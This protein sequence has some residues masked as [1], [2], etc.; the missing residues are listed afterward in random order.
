[1][2][3]NFYSRFLITALFFVMVSGSFAYAIRITT[4]PS[5]IAECS[6]F[7]GIRS[8]TV[9]A[10]GL[11]LTYQWQYRDGIKWT[12]IPHATGSTYSF[13]WERN[14]PLTTSTNGMAIRCRITETGSYHYTRIAYIWVNNNISTHPA[15]QAKVVGQSVTFTVAATG[16]GKLTY[17]W[18]KGTKNISGA[19]SSS[20]TI[21]SVKTGD[22]GSYNC[23]VTG[24]CNT[25]T[26]SSATLTVYEQVV[27]TKQPKPVTECEGVTNTSIQVTATGP[28]T[29]YQWQV[30]PYKQITWQ[31]ITGATSNPLVNPNPLS[32]VNNG[33]Q[34]RCIVYG[35]GGQSVTSNAA[36]LTV[37]QKAGI[38]GHPAS[39]TRNTGESVTF[40][41]SSTGYSRSW[42]WEVNKGSGWS[43]VAGATSSSLTLS[44]LTLSDAGSYRC[45]VYNICNTVHTNA[46]V[47]TIN[48]PPYPD[49]W[50][51]QNSGS[52]LNILAIH[53]LS[54]TKAW[55]VTQDQNKLLKTINGGETWLDVAASGNNYWRTVFFTSENIGFIGGYNGIART[56]DGGVNW[57]YTDL[58][59]QES[60]GA[61]EYFYI[62]SI[63][64]VNA[65]TGW[66]VG[67]GGI[68]YKTTNGGA[69][70]GKI[71]W[72][73]DNPKVTDINLYSVYFIN[74]NT[75]FVAGQNGAMY[76]T[77]EGGDTPA[78]WV[79]VTTGV[80]GSNTI[81]D[82]NF[83]NTEKGFFISTENKGLYSTINGGL[84]WTKIASSGLLPDVYSIYLRSL[85]FVDA[86]N[87]YLAGYKWVSS[88][89][90][91]IVIK[92]FD[93]GTTWVE[94]SVEPANTIYK[95]R[96]LDANHGWFVGQ[97]GDI[98]RT[99]KGGCHTPFVSLYDDQTLCSG[100]NHLLVADTFANNVNGARYSW[101]PGGQ[102]TGKLT[103]NTTN[104]Y[105]V[106]LTNECNVS[107]NDNVTITF[108]PLP[109]ASAGDNTAIC[110]GESTQL[111]AS[112]GLSYLWNNESLLDD[113]T[114]PNPIATPVTNTTFTV[115]VTDESGCFKS[116]G[117]TVTVNPIPGSDFNTPS[118]IC[119]TD[120]G[121]FTYNGS[122]AGKTFDWDFGDGNI[123]SGSDGGP[124][125]VNWGETGDKMVS[126]VTTQN[127][128]VS[129]M[130][131]K[132][133]DVRIKPSSV[134]L[135][136]EA[137]CG[138]NG[139]VVLYTGGAPESSDFSWTY[140]GGT[141]LGGSAKDSFQLSWDT[142]GTKTVS[143]H[144]TQNGCVS[145]V[146]A[147]DIIVSYPFDQEKICIVTIDL[148]TG[149]NMVVWERT[150]N[151]GVTSY[152]IYRNVSGTY[153]L[154]GNVPVGDIS[155]FVDMTSNPESYQ[156]FYKI[157]S[158]DTCG[159]ESARSK[160]HRTMF[161]QYVGNQLSW[162]NY[163]VEEGA[164]TFSSNKIY[165]GTSPTSLAEI[166]T[167]DA[168]LRLFTDTEGNSGN[169]KLYY[170][171]A[172]V[173]AS[174]C[175]PAETGGKKASSGPFVHSFSNL[176]DNRK[177]GTGIDDPLA[178]ILNL[179]VYPN[180]F[181]EKT[182]L[183]Y[184][185]P[186]ESNVKIEVFN[187]I[188]DKVIE[189]IDARQSPGMHSLNIEAPQLN[190][191][192]G[193]YYVKVS[194]D[195]SY[196]I[197]KIMMVQ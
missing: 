50:Y 9:V 143:L 69:N 180:P 102:T 10:S 77:T 56:D 104:T 1:M 19:T 177:S 166:Q 127:G 118:Y 87:G 13:E 28:V 110:S 190:N 163:Q 59:S 119:G 107:A 76:K 156:A 106:T 41:V 100:E 173:L 175:A 183:K 185:L 62:E 174:Q 195:N 168:S 144:V 70:W 131:Q 61:T 55:A 122:A 191:A 23:V 149:K 75:G 138:S 192:N 193:L 167:L 135:L 111:N 71:S 159:N 125:M 25:V 124:Y 30:L 113:N 31:N 121:E 109:D 24:G 29:G 171:V 68:I 15:S 42:Q 133:I 2:K 37:R 137:I 172:G 12:N 78:E 157:S 60:L 58:R 18:R 116:S 164:I 145:P 155:L 105:S 27:V 130:T 196:I 38:T 20:H 197:R 16:K 79:E 80:A 7:T 187:I 93:G 120:E 115:T 160:Y 6:G 86:N 112:G 142:K 169:Q 88:T 158:V 34:F 91:G 46:A 132:I 194:V 136:P 123:V 4:Q 99:G 33:D 90:K 54:E 39:A 26:S 95:I 66:A 148:E 153:E 8:M 126:L 53:P 186:K 146:T 5:D 92:T 189:L 65:N 162:D 89:Q 44:N 57:N 74:E 85:D 63:F 84:E 51:K 32:L 184:S 73:N 147:N 45:K 129:P 82:I 134:F 151:M 40:N 108:R 48:L 96:M 67:T 117:V 139:A 152:N 101:S 182:L 52:S 179:Q 14:N 176:E 141:F 128:C 97:A 140:D 17:Q 150:P 178:D 181:K 114:I 83:V 43:Q 188:G 36:L 3:N 170:R 103:V 47:L 72:K 21:S 35:S 81:Y 22:A 98:F 49:G 154:I 64:F 11:S 161:L 94:Q 165:R